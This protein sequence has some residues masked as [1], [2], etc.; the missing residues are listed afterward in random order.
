LDPKP[1]D[2]KPAGAVGYDPKP[3]VPLRDSVAQPLVKGFLR[4]R[5]R[6]RERERERKRDQ[7]IKGSKG[8]EGR[9]EGKG[10]VGFWFLTLEKAL[11][12]R[13]VDLKKAWS[14]KGR[15]GEKGFWVLV[16]LTCFWARVLVFGFWSMIDGVDGTKVLITIRGIIEVFWFFF[17]LAKRVQNK[18]FFTCF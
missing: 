14:S 17:L 13:D 6:E 8:W 18:G 9:K 3:F 7:R 2:P 1:K 15:E 10:F 16:V 4:E 12:R 5:K 11:W